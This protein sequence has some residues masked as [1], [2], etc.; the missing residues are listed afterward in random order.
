MVTTR[1][2]ELSTEKGSKSEQPEQTE[3]TI[4]EAP[5]PSEPNDGKNEDDAASQARDRQARF[6]ALQARA[7]SIYSSCS[8]ALF[9]LFCNTKLTLHRNPPR[10]AT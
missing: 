2:Q 5:T 9:C 4:S 1:N 3:G 10:N 6:K 7:V 8:K